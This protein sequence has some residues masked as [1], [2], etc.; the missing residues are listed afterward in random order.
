MKII[1]A[2]ACLLAIASSARGLDQDA[3]IAK[4]ME[5]LMPDVKPCADEF[6][7]TE[8]QASNI[9]TA[10]ATMDLRQMGCMK[11]CVMKRMN[12]LTGLDFHLE[13]IYKMIDTVH[14]GNDGE[15]A[16]VR[17]IA[18][19]CVAEINGETDECNIGNKYTDCYIAKLFS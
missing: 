16:D 11:A 8:E 3:V 14:T 13:P 9:Q 2:V 6:H 12:I 7:M 19:S 5:Y 1:I 18:E 17:N 4:Y 10:A 15:I